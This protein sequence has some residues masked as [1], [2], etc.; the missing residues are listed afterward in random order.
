MKRP[1]YVLGSARYYELDKSGGC[2]KGTWGGQ[3]IE[4]LK[5]EPGDIVIDSPKV[6][7]FMGTDLDIILKNLERG[8]MI[9]C[10]VET[11]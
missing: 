10:G 9:V 4:E 7:G 2:I 6:D 8:V 5:P 1:G 11:K 3:V